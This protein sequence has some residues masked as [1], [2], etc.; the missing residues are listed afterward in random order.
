MMTSRACEWR[1]P[2]PVPAAHQAADSYLSLVR[3]S[4]PA[5]NYYQGGELKE[6]E[7]FV[8]PQCLVGVMKDSPSDEGSKTKTCTACEWV[9]S[10]ECL[11][12]YYKSCTVEAG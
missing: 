5:A 7:F 10:C 4:L 3:N 12:R 2:K 8:C 9:M 1:G 6:G 11:H